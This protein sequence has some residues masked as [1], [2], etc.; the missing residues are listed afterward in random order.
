MLRHVS[1]RTRY[2][3]VRLAFHPYPQVIQWLFTANWFCP[4]VGVTPPSTCPWVA[5][6]VSGLPQLTPRP[7]QTRF[8][9]GFAS[10]GLTSP[11][12]ITRRL[13][14]QKARGH[15]FGLPLLVGTR[16]QVLFHSPPGVL[17]TFPSRYFC[18][19]GQQGVFS[20]GGWSPLIPTGFLVPRGT[21]DHN[22]G[23]L[24]PFAYGTFTLSGGP[25]QTLQLDARFVTPRR[26]CGLAQLRPSTPW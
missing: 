16:F 24:A 11:A 20:L 4:P 25:S 3:R 7:F 15:P 12:T 18:A 14:N 26:V 6:P 2:H 9:F 19:I 8:P 13:I 23:S 22:P 17:F 1:G 10:P 5:H 21:R